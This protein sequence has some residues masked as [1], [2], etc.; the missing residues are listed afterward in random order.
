MLLIQK[1]K[2][3]LNL[4]YILLALIFTFCF[5]QIILSL[6]NSQLKKI[7]DQEFKNHSDK[8]ENC[9]DIKNNNKRTFYENIRLS[10]Y[11][12]DKFGSI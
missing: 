6:K 7:K 3:N 10:E 9:I 2:P 11:C 12:I 8:I 1:L 5:I 4:L